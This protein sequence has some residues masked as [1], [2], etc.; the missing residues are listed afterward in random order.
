MEAADRIDRLGR[1]ALALL[2][3]AGVWLRTSSLGRLPDPNG[4]EA[5]YGVQAGHLLRGQAFAWRTPNGNPLDPFNAGLQVPLQAIF[6]PRG[7]VLRVPAW[8]SGVLTIGAAAFW[9]RRRYG[10]TAAR[11]AAGGVAVLPILIGTSRMGFDSSLTPLF[12][13]VALGAASCGCWGTMGGAYLGALLAHPTN[14]F[15]LPGLGIVGLERVVSASADRADWRWFAGVMG[16]LTALSVVLG[17]TLV[18]RSAAKAAHSA[19]TASGIGEA[20]AGLVRMLLATPPG[21]GCVPVGPV[22]GAGVVVVVAGLWG[23]KRQGEP[24]RAGMALVAAVGANLG[25]LALV[26]GA[27]SLCAGNPVDVG[28]YR[29]GLSLA[30]PTVLATS[31]LLGALVGWPERRHVRQLLGAGVLMLGVGLLIVDRWHR[32]DPFPADPVEWLGTPWPDGRALED[33]VARGG[34]VGVDFGREL[35]ASMASGVPGARVGAGLEGG[36]AFGAS[37]G[38]GSDRRRGGAMA[39]GRGVCGG[40]CGRADRG[41]GASAVWAG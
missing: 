41:V 32:V 9:T 17:M 25:A 6:G 27:G 21:G 37:A 19:A 16:G 33:R 2:V 26:A 24:G 7:W 11:I 39:R 3:L 38:P 5:Y 30:G 13:V 14:L 4:D 36:G 29:Y 34:P 10:V 28:H 20:P 12:S 23:L 40:V 8:L 1:M 15:L 18:D 22:L 35:V 31:V